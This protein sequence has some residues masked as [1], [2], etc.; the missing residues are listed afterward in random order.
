MK[1]D[2]LDWGGGGGG[3]TKVQLK[4]SCCE[5]SMCFGEMIGE[6]NY[7]NLPKN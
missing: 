2:V 7:Q 6:N 4:A 5:K 3:M 1:E